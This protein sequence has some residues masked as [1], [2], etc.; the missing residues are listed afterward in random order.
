MCNNWRRLY[1]E[2]FSQAYMP[3]ARIKEVPQE[4]F[5]CE[6]CDRFGIK[7]KTIISF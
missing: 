6:D 3:M 2:Q 5:Y 1:K 7:P 4:C